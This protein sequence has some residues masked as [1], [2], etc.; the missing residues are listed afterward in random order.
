MK[1]FSSLPAETPPEGFIPVRPED[2]ELTVVDYFEPVV[3][4]YADNI[5]IK[6]KYSEI[7]YRDYNTFSNQCARAILNIIGDVKDQPVLFLADHS[8]SSIIAIMGILKTGNI[9]VALDVTNPIERLNSIIEDS[10]GRL[11]ITSNL[12]LKLAKE[13]SSLGIQILNLDT[14]DPNLPKE[15]LE[16]RTSSR[17]LAVIFY[18]SG[19]TG[20]PKGVLLDHRAL[21]ERVC[22]KINTEYIYDK[23][24]L[25]LPFPVGFGWST[26]PVFAA[27]LTG[28]ILYVRSYNDMSLTDLQDWLVINKITYMPASASFLRQFLTSLPVDGKE[29][30]PELRTIHAGGETF[31]PQDIINFEK[32]FSESTRLVYSLS[33]TEAGGITKIFY[34]TNTIIN[35][36]LISVGYLF[37]SMKLY[38][39]DE[40]DKPVPDNTVGQIALQSPAILRGYW[41]RPELNQRIFIADPTDCEKNIFLSG[42]MGRIL[43][44]GE[45]E[46][47]GR[48]DNQIK[49]RGFRIDTAEVETAL[50]KHPAV[51]N[52]IVLGWSDKVKM[53]EPILVAY[54]SL[55]KGKELTVSE[56]RSFMADN[57]PEYMLPT[58]YL[59]LKELPLNQNGKVDR[60]AL[61]DPG[62]D[63]PEIQSTFEAPASDLE[64]D[65]CKIWQE[66]LNV[67]HIGVQDDFFELGGSSLTALQMIIRVEKLVKHK[68]SP[69]FFQHPT[70]LNLIADIKPDGYKRV[71][72]N[73]DAKQSLSRKSDVKTQK[74]FRYRKLFIQLESAL[75]I[76]PFLSLLNKSFVD[77]IQR[78]RKVAHKP[79]VNHLIYGYQ[80]GLLRG[81]MA[82]LTDCH[83]SPEQVMPD[84]IIGNVL[85]N[86]FART[87]DDDE[88]IESA[89]R[90]NNS[91][92]RFWKD[93]IDLI[94]NKPLNEIEDFFAV[95]GFEILTQALKNN[96]GVILLTYHSTVGRFATMALKQRLGDKEIVTINQRVA[97]Q[98]SSKWEDFG[99]KKDTE[100]FDS[101]LFANEALKGQHLLMEGKIIQLVGDIEYQDAKHKLV[102]SRR[103]YGLKT[104]FAELALNTGA[105]VIPVFNTLKPDG[106]IHTIFK[107]ALD[108]GSGDR[109]TQIG[110]LMNGY[111]SFM[112]SAWSE[113]PESLKWT[114]LRSHIRKPVS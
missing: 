101:A 84:S 3:E 27:L 15:N 48:K 41:Q 108:P 1:L 93:L 45:L 9:Y 107:P 73:I 81:F 33:S 4:K 58:R 70:I 97:R 83:R 86:M 88:S 66:V 25:L 99:A 61:P 62:T 68:I 35:M 40:N 96:K 72:G 89:E 43:P 52:A 31:H 106:R 50:Y 102:L 78:L 28:A 109:E 85:I 54:L 94:N 63:R 12:N 5:A 38:I 71:D 24:R 113:A 55:K 53:A 6:D 77:G 49:I 8:I 17:N 92:Y 110:N 90:L 75:V 76:F 67:D 18:T 100:A 47:L 19:S 2:F 98:Q 7:S 60:K 23:D 91:T 65:L 105:L 46:F 39:L 111:V 69:N 20:K 44:N 30:F 10:Q 59:F 34:Y 37:N 42:D 95:S 79:W 14:L 32:H 112:N 51:K 36:D 16:K 103:K 11:I 56:L 74:P 80:Y 104:G 82:T 29:L 21:M 87:V 64:E 57:L 26:Q 114:R 13:L 22:A